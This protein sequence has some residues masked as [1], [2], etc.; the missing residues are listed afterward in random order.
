MKFKTEQ[1]DQGENFVLPDTDPISTREVLERRM[2][3]AAKATKAQKSFESTEIFNGLPPHQD[4]L[5]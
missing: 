4:T 1:T 5:F 2:Q 3:G